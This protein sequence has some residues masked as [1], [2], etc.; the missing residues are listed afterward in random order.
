MLAGDVA[1]PIAGESSTASAKTTEQH[2]SSIVFV[3]AQIE[4]LQRTLD[5]IDPSAEIVLI[6]SKTDVIDQITQLLST[7]NSVGALHFIGHGQQGK[8]AFGDQFIEANT[9]LER[10]EPNPHLEIVFV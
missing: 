7:K 10:Q 6:D 4:D 9:L 5:A 8:V 2:Q 3:D 1:A